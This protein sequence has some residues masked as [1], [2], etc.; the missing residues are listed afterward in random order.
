MSDKFSELDVLEAR[1]VATDAGLEGAEVLMLP[2]NVVAAMC[3]GI[4]PEWMP[5]WA[6]SFLDSR[7]PT[8]QVPAMIHD[9]QYSLADGSEE[10][11]HAAN[12]MLKENGKR[13]AK[14]RYGWWNPL[15]YVAVRDACRLA[16]VC[17]AFGR[18]AYD[19]AVSMSREVDN[20]RSVADC[21]LDGGTCGCVCGHQCNR[22][23]T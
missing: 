15:R 22:K 8:M 16:A 1:R 23:S 20:D 11:F 3:N 6:R 12:A 2:P 5:E 14:Y 17:E 18:S 7:H 13:M 21:T 4:G 10:M 9:M 19:Q